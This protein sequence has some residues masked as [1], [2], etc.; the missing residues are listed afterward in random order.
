MMDGGKKSLLGIM[1][2]AVDYE[3]AVDRVVTAAKRR[4]PFVV[5]A[6]AVHGTMTGA[7][8]AEHRFRL[9][10]F[11]LLVPDGQ[12][13]RWALNFLYGTGLK[14]RVYGPKL[15][16]LLLQRAAEEKLPVYLYGTTEVI[17]SQLQRELSKRFPDLLIAGSSPSAFRKLS[18]E[19]KVAV[20]EK[21]RRSG[22]QIVFVGLGCP[23][24]EVWAYEYREALSIPIIAI[25]AAFPF[26]AGTLAQA[27]GVLQRCGLEWLFRLMKE[28]KRL[29]R[30]YVF[31]NP[32]Y[33]YL[34]GLQRFGRR[35]DPHGEPPKEELLFG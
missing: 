9:N 7:L 4:L 11:D 34:V 24:Q 13:V 8:D 1:I 16:L 3:A 22:S 21:I 15:T 31:L 12:P 27:P 33:I 23:R 35:F 5:S 10:R 25:G 26:I 19:E 32:A 6:L 2:D 17:L 14:D 18:P 28:P 20:V 30:R 29:W